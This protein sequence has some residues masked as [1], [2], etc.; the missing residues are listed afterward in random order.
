[1]PNIIAKYRVPSKSH[2]GTYHVVNLYDSGDGECDEGC[3]GYGIHGTC[4]HVKKA[5]EFHHKKSDTAGAGDAF[6]PQPQK[7]VSTNATRTIP[8]PDQTPG[9]KGPVSV[10]R[11]TDEKLLQDDG[12]TTHQPGLGNPTVDERKKDEDILPEG[13]VQ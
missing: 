1:M 9:G 13:S 2:P 4:S 5:W 3:F 8:R 11:E 6:Q 12:S 7:N 10:L